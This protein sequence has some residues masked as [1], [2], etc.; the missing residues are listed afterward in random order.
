MIQD[1][2]GATDYAGL[3]AVGRR[4]YLEFAGS[5]GDRVAVD[6]L[7][8]AR[9]EYVVGLGHVAGDDQCF[10][11]EQVD[12]AREYLADVAPTFPDQPPGFGVAAE[13][14]STRSR[15]CPTPRPCC[16]MVR[17]RAQPP[18]MA[19][20][21]PVSPH[22]QATPAAAAVLVCPN[23]PA[24]PTA[25]RW[26]A[27]PV[28]ILRR[29]TLYSAIANI[30]DAK[31]LLVRVR[32]VQNLFS[33]TSAK[34][35]DQ[36]Y[37][38]RVEQRAIGEIMIDTTVTGD[39]DLPPRTIGYATFRR[40]LGDEAFSKWFARFEASLDAPPAPDQPDRLR[41]IH[42]ALIDLINFLDPDQERFPDDRL[43]LPRDTQLA[44]GPRRR[45]P[46][47]WSRHPRPAS[48]TVIP[49]FIIARG[50]PPAYPSAARRGG[51]SVSDGVL[52]ARWSGLVVRT[53]S[54]WYL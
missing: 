42:I 3:V 29:Y 49:P 47:T 31:K 39:R 35:R 30:G 28:E 16:C 4:Q 1:H 12:G 33:Q 34:Y 50:R 54:F 2:C 45:G 21:Q 32:A 24:P 52:A 40:C 10:G 51:M 41:Q 53:R 48:L 6:G 27:P 7:A 18:A 38:Y 22:R 43:P 17:T 19:S 37:I 26:S 15:M 23:S 14:R 5:Q 11:V 25:P 44:T 36:R 20:R 13:V 9:D 8:Q 46:L